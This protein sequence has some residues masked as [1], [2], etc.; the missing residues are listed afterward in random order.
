MN[1][2]TYE[3]FKKYINELIEKSIYEY[4][5]PDIYIDKP[6][7]EQQIEI[8]CKYVIISNQNELISIKNN[9]NKLEIIE[10]K[11]N[12]KLK[13]ILFNE[14]EYVTNTI[15]IENC[16][17]I[18][19]LQLNSLIST[20][21]LTIQGISQNINKSNLNLKLKSS[22]DGIF[23]NEYH[24]LYELNLDE[25]DICE[26]INI[27]NCDSLK[28]ININNIKYIKTINISHCPS[29]ISISFDNLINT[30]ILQIESCD[31]LNQ[32]KILKLEK[33]SNILQLINIPGNIKIIN[34]ILDKNRTID[35]NKFY[36]DK[37]KKYINILYN[38]IKNKMYIIN[39]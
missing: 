2:K 21:E 6:I 18:E 20:K 37:F 17:N 32:I 27:T 25:L 5:N 9:R 22:I 19:K 12:L 11:N 1:F 30:E 35:I 24:S 29:L 15:C 7:N 13:Y 14:L 10:L 8:K 26:R 36:Y 16:N 39:F 23:I 31:Q 4:K 33:I 3:E 38:S 34:N 28:K